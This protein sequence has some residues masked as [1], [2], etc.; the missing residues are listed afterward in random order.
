MTFGYVSAHD[1]SRLY[2]LTASQVYRRAY[3]GGWRRYTFEGE[4]YYHRQD[5]D[6]TLNPVLDKPETRGRSC[7]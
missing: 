2:R 1:V 3:K 6:D 4:V 5:V 7:A